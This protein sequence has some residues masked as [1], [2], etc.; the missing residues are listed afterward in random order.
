MYDWEESDGGNEFLLEGS[1]CLKD[2]KGRSDHKLQRTIGAEI[3][4]V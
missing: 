3:E 4:G 2:S 1:G